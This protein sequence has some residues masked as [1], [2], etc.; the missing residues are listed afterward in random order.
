M[1]PWL[2]GSHITDSFPSTKH[3]IT[4]HFGGSQGVLDELLGI[5][6][7]K[8]S[9]LELSMAV[10]ENRGPISK[11]VVNSLFDKRE[12]PRFVAFTNFSGVNTLTTVDFKVSG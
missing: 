8:L 2:C 10:S 11:V 7:G 12:K 4:K 1:V 5:C 6:L 9:E 3:P